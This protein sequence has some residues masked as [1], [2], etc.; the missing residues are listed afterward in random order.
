[1]EDIHLDFVREP[2]ITFF[3]SFVSAFLNYAKINEPP[4][5]ADALSATIMRALFKS[6]PVVELATVSDSKTYSKAGFWESDF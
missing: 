4:G 3:E 6:K 5:F 1:V 2:T